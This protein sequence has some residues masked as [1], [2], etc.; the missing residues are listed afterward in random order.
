MTPIYALPG[1]LGLPSDWTE[2]KKNFSSR[3]VVSIDPYQI[4]KPEQGLRNWAQKF[5]K[6]IEK[7]PILLGYSMGARLGMHALLENSSLFKAMV[8]VSGNPGLKTQEE[9]QKRLHLDHTWAERFLKE[10]W[11][12]LMR[13]WNSLP[14]FV[15]SPIFRQE[16]DYCRKQLSSTLIHWSVARQT[17]FSTILEQTSLPILWV[18]G[19]LDKAYS[20]SARAMRFSNPLS[21]IQ[22]VPSASHR[23]PWEK[24]EKFHAI[25]H[26]FLESIK[27][28]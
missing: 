17:D 7:K 3:T 24:P 5:V 23:V 12:S 18:A 19:A 1:F 11:D 13:S 20:D 22:I 16:K 14:L 25:L 8:F 4:A 15:K 27:G 9:K 10:P 2:L 6:T 26:R 28:I 21:E